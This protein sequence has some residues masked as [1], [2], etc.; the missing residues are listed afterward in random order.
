MPY[1][2]LVG[3]L[4]VVFAGLLVTKVNAQSPHFRLQTLFTGVDQCLDIINDG[5]NDQPT[6]APCS[7]V[8]GQLWNLSQTP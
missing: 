7:N 1:K 6:M 3:M 5:A 2:Q 8:S 4:S